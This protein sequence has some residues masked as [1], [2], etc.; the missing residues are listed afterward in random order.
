[1][2]LP[3][4]FQFS[5]TSL[6]DYADCP[7]RFQLR[8]LMQLAWPAPQV[9]PVDEHEYLYQMGREFHRLAHQ[10][11]L[12]IPAEALS[13]SVSD[14]EL[15]RW[16]GAFL[17]HATP[18]LAGENAIPEVGL[19]TSLEGYRLLAQYDAIVFNDTSDSPAVLILDWKTHRR[20]PSRDWFARRLQ[21]RVYP[22]VLVQAGASLI[23]GQS[24]LPEAIKMYYWLAEY[25]D[26]PEI[27]RYDATVYQTDV[28]Y[29]SGLIREITTLPSDEIWPLTDN[30]RR[31]QFCNYRSLCGRGTQAG[32]LE[33][34]AE[35]GDFGDALD[36]S[37]EVTAGESPLD[38][39]LDWGQVQEIAY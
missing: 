27:F 1:M 24:I 30:L 32:L 2:L 38:F 4:N 3:E 37:A 12:D 16:W 34:F 6:Q 21:T 9:D 31:C 8:Y 23:G 39:D 28:E 20:R 18:L 35:G 33:E 13:A 25:P 11:L 5:A 15:R 29:V 19:S 26:A 7:R 22:L 17:L 14:D 10:Y 36:S